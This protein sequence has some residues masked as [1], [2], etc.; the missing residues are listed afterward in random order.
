MKRRMTGL[1]LNCFLLAVAHASSSSGSAWAQDQRAEAKPAA[2]NTTAAKKTLAEETFSSSSSRSSTSSDP[3]SPSAIQASSGEKW[4]ED[5]HENSLGLALLRNL[6]ADQ[7]AMWSSPKRLRL[8]DADWLL[9]LGVAA[10]GMLATD[11]EYSKHL[12]NSPGRLHDS[13]SFSNYGLGALAGVGG[14]FYF[15]GLMTHDDHRSETGLLAGEAA[16]D[17]FGMTYGLKYAFGRERP[18]TNQYRGNFWQGSDSFP[19][20]H[21]AA[22]WSIASVIAHEYPGPLTTFLAYGL[23]SAVSVSR[24]TAKQHFPSDV[25]IGSAIG[26]FV[27]QHVYR[28]HHHPEIGGGEWLSYAEARDE[29]VG[30]RPGS[31]G[32]PYVELDSWIYPALERLRA[33]GF[34]HM[35]FLGMRPWTRIEC[36]RMVEEAGDKIR[37]QD[38]RSSEPSR[39]YETLAREFQS[40][41]EA[42]D[43][44]GERS[45]RVESVYAGAT[46]ITGSPLND[47]R[48]FGQS[49]INNSGRPYERGFNNY[50][51]FSGYATE[52]RFTVYVRGEYQHSPSAPAYSLAARAAISAVDGEPLDPATPVSAANKFRLLDTY[53]A[54]NVA[55]WN[56]AFGKQSLWWGPGLGS[57]MLFSN[58]AEPIYMFRASRIAPFRLPW[59]FRY[60]GPIKTDAFFGKLSGDR[61]PPRPLLHGEKISFKPTTNLEVGFTRTVEIGG[62]GRALTLGHVWASYSALGD[63]KNE[64]ALNDPGKRTGGF[65]FSYRV[66]FARDWLT[67]YADSIT[68]DDPSPLD[69]PRRAGINSGIYLARVPK[70]AK[71]DFR[72]EGVYTDTPTARS[73]RG[74]YIYYDGFYHDLYT[75]KNNIIGSWVGREGQGIQ[76]WTTYWIS[77]RNSVQL[78]YRHA[79]VDG[80]FIPGGGT[81]ND[82]SVKTN[83]WR[84]GEWNFSA[85]LQY[86]KWKFPL[87]A[88]T[89]QTNW[90]ASLEIGFWPRSWSKA[91]HGVSL[92]SFDDRFQRAP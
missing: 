10:G 43:G 5:S 37:G 38:R 15:W 49:I 26:W 91:M 14:G 55:D 7:K 92:L 16:M 60:M 63:V 62:V 70:F 75:D 2:V 9:P 66:P 79:K 42:A 74:H 39:L 6:A 77:A 23:A 20:E 59:I 18:L 48:H 87:L 51:G 52:G 22:A 53:V 82:A 85:F 58:N 78:G 54:A 64:T 25:L 68:T 69:A 83:F 65:E 56:L 3:A 81:L 67:V 17:S 36:A 12:S 47:S 80:D 4:H 28:A 27:G 76:A 90:T 34:I 33:L 41:L 61:F 13:N 35:E 21:A 71:L 57:A 44:G 29:I 88:T 1:L 30:G 31:V 73:N 50:D 11:T 32:S 40:G 72:A 45:I 84:N 24:V 8:A 19:S 46:E 86:E 89:A